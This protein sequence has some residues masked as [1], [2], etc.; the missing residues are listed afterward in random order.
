MSW[1]SNLIK[2]VKETESVDFLLSDPMPRGPSSPREL[3]VDESY[4]SVRVA[5][6]R[7]PNTRQKVFDRV[8][9]VVHAFAHVASQAG[10][11]IEFAATTMPGKLAGVDPK[12][13]QN[14][15][16][17]DKLVVGPTPWTGGDF[18]LE[19][20]LFS[21]VSENLAG[22][23]LETMSKLSETVGV[24]FAA[25]AKPYVETIR[26]GVER[27]TAAQGSIKLE[28]GLDKTFIPPIPGSYALVAAPVGT[29]NP[30]SLSLN[31][32]DGKVLLDGT[33]YT[34]KP[35][36]VFTIESSTQR[37]D[38]GDIPE[39]RKAYA[40]VKD[41]I[42]TNDQTKAAQ[43]FQGFRREA[44]IS[45]DLIPNDAKRLIAK[46]DGVLNAA[47]GTAET[48]TKSR[49]ALRQIPEFHELSLYE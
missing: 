13:L 5:S 9:G 42:S 4:I 36:L 24:A 21:V 25:A 23:F 35:Y 44:T 48:A 11:V 31:T 20:G 3:T 6:L 10:Q 17:I 34:A 40:A 14:V 1:L 28:I 26:F 45:S 32:A 12:G 15:I 49:K 46:V 29:L 18:V 33:H 19:I 8:Y 47:F 39:L 22:P 37:A 41:A 16:T 38:W 7:L 43:A 30:K 2:R 27:L